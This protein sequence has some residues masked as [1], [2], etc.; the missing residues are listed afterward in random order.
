[1]ERP[2]SPGARGVRNGRDQ[3]RPHAE[4]QGAAA[5]DAGRAGA[6]AR[7]RSRE[8]DFSEL[9]LDDESEEES[10][11]GEVLKQRNLV[12]RLEEQLAA[13]ALHDHP[14]K[15]SVLEAAAGGAEAE[16][17]L[18][19]ATQRLERSIRRAQS[20]AGSSDSSKKGGSGRAAAA[21]RRRRW[22]R[23]QQR[24]HP[25]V[26][27]GRVG[28]FLNVREVLRRYGVFQEEGEEG[29][30]EEG[31]AAAESSGESQGALR[32]SSRKTRSGFARWTSWRSASSPIGRGRGR[33]LD[34]R[35]CTRR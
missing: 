17:E 8:V 27:D 25:G 13:H 24:V 23:R 9:L 2:G 22:R 35:S 21:G 3:R 29:E 19:R 32:S 1:M 12:A 15:E 34:K 10:E 6:R 30:Q 28:R 5:A 4:R 14:S 16:A 26:G 20:S 18:K 11:S 7:E 31:G 33:H